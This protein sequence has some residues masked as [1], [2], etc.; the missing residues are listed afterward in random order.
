MGAAEWRIGVAQQA[1]NERV[2]QV[3]E[4]EGDGAKL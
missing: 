3:N 1:N 4:A 2:I